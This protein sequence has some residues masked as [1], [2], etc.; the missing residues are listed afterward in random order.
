MPQCPIP[1]NILT[2]EYT[3]LQARCPR[4]F[5]VT[6]PSKAYYKLSISELTSTSLSVT[7]VDNRLYYLSVAVLVCH[8]SITAYTSLMVVV[9]HVNSC[10]ETVHPFCRFYACNKFRPLKSS[11]GKCRTLALFTSDLLNILLPED[12][13]LPSHRR[14][15]L[16]ICSQGNLTA[17][18]MTS[19]TRHT[20]RQ[21]R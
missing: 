2:Y 14:T 11:Q 21:C 3:Y 4:D 19:A 6:Y 17:Q 5:A 9:M 10:A 12:D 8:F 13:H 1:L 20:T 7:E 15:D 18:D 16:L